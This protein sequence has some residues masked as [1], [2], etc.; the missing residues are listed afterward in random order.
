MQRIIFRVTETTY[1]TPEPFIPDGAYVILVQDGRAQI[2]RYEAPQP[3]TD[4]FPRLE[5]AENW[6]MLEAQAR[7]AI[8]EAFPDFDKEE[9]D[10]AKTFTCPAEL[11]NKA[12]WKEKA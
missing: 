1:G 8:K 6:E 9:T 11:A 7:D 5:S 4:P 12:T 3:P 10:I 2:C